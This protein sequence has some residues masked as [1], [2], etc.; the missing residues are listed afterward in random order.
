MDRTTA[1][2]K[3]SVATVKLVR[4]GVRWE[5]VAL[6]VAVATVLVSLT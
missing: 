6:A 1:V 5:V 4:C 3:R 2:A